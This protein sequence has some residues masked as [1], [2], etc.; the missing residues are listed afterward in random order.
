MSR[1]HPPTTTPNP[2]LK[3]IGSAMPASSTVARHVTRAAIIRSPQGSLGAQ[4]GS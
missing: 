1:Q 3:R 2:S 4:N